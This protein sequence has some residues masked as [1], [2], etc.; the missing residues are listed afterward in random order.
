ML[1]P[2]E[3]YW[4]LIKDL[5]RV[6]GLHEKIN[7]EVL[8]DPEDPKIV[9]VLNEL[10]DEVLETLATNKRH[11]ILKLDVNQYSVYELQTIL[12][13]LGIF[14]K[15][16]DDYPG[17]TV[18]AKERITNTIK[19]FD[20]NMGRLARF[21]YKESPE[22]WQKLSKSIVSQ[23]PP[24]VVIAQSLK[25]G[26]F[27][28]GATINTGNDFAEKLKA[29][30]EV[31]PDFIRN[32]IRKMC[33]SWAAA[34][35]IPWSWKHSQQKGKESSL[36]EN[37]VSPLFECVQYAING[38]SITQH[39]GKTLSW[40]LQDIKTRVV[41]QTSNYNPKSAI[42]QSL[43]RVHESFKYFD[44]HGLSSMVSSKIRFRSFNARETCYEERKKQVLNNKFTP[45]ADKLLTVPKNPRIRRMIVVQDAVKAILSFLLLHGIWWIL[46]EVG[47]DLPGGRKRFL[48]SRQDESRR[49]GRI[50]G[51]FGIDTSMASDS[52]T[53]KLMK[54]YVPDLYSYL[55]EFSTKSVVDVFNVVER[56]SIVFTGM[57]S[58][59]CFPLQT[60]I[61]YVICERVL[62]Q[63]GIED[64]PNKLFVYGDDIVFGDPLRTNND[65]LFRDCC[66]ELEKF[67]L[68]VNRKKSFCSSS[69]ITEVCGAYNYKGKDIRP[70]MIR[71]LN[72]DGLTDMNDGPS[73][74]SMIA[75]YNSLVLKGYKWA[76]AVVKEE[77]IRSR[78]Y[79]KLLFN[80][81]GFSSYCLL[82]EH[83]PEKHLYKDQDTLA[84]EALNY[85]YADI[86]KDRLIEH[87]GSGFYHPAE[88]GFYYPFLYHAEKSGIIVEKADNNISGKKAKSKKRKFDDFNRY[89]VL[90]SKGRVKIST[91]SY[92]HH[93]R[94]S[95]LVT[96]E[97]Y[98]EYEE[99]EN[100]AEKSKRSAKAKRAEQKN[101][102]V[103]TKSRK[104]KSF[105]MSRMFLFVRSDQEC[106]RK[107]KIKEVYS[108]NL[109]HTQHWLAVN[110]V[111]H[112]YG[113]NL[114]PED[115]GRFLRSKRPI[116]ELHSFFVEKRVEKLRE[117][118]S[119]HQKMVDGTY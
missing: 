91:Q 55:E 107:G 3:L 67:G 66:N 24:S 1:K 85:Q 81:F 90:D 31:H 100:S 42:R 65:D 95:K 64:I 63:H 37:L 106:N 60:I 92:S 58:I 71:R 61:F 97:T 113:L 16:S 13:C 7:L 27:P 56:P 52:I 4:G 6:K 104:S 11:H 12:Q 59:F 19:K 70:T 9:D 89:N 80:T 117:K 57:G 101:K 79:E 112:F 54:E 105:I 103:K 114:S 94:S 43:L 26:T 28:K 18:G 44:K 82:G 8:P 62:M 119:A 47:L 21:E 53:R 98:E 2:N 108:E 77:I 29:L 86:D 46:E 14:A 74:V 110:T 69:P 109:I 45:Y 111:D 49:I 118:Q 96:T 83:Q 38:K 72:G 51:A 41:R 22:Y 75:T 17:Q 5:E 25:M 84:I 116:S 23:L 10:F 93:I 48:F 73:V 34:A 30:S 33:V 102:N 39:G 20:D 76:A 40:S 88:F 115:L 35:E 36:D 87:N 99:K 15:L 78:H 50:P 32:T 68:V